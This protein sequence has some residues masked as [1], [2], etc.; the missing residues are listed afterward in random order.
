MKNF[1]EKTVSVFLSWR[2]IL[3]SKRGQSKAYFVFRFGENFEKSTK[4]AESHVL[5]N[6][7]SPALMYVKNYVEE[8][9]LGTNKKV[10]FLL[11]F[12]LFVCI[13]FIQL[14]KLF[15]SVRAMCMEKNKKIFS[16]RCKKKQLFFNTNF[17]LI[18][19]VFFTSNNSFNNFCCLIFISSP[20]ID[21]DTICLFL[22]ISEHI[23]LNLLT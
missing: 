21:L 9:K 10:I 4:A 18:S 12:Q 11:I 3:K 1:S 13:L 8:N 17:E 5:A 19:L 22:D 7:K 6:E 14:T 20:A 16:Q 2:N 15:L 23:D